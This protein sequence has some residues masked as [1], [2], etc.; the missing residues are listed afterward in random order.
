LTYSHSPE[1][2]RNDDTVQ[3]RLPSLTRVRLH[4]PPESFQRQE[5]CV[6]VVVLAGFSG[7]VYELDT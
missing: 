4:F 1:S 2:N 3:S 5:E 7:V 6:Q